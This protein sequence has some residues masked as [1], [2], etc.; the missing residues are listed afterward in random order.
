MDPLAN[1]M[2]T[3]VTFM[4][5]KVSK[6]DTHNYNQWKVDMEL[7]KSA[8]L[9][10][11]VH[12]ARPALPS[13]DWLKKEVLVLT[14]IRQHCT[15]DAGSLI[16]DLF[17]ANT[18]WDTLKASFEQDTDENENRLWGDFSIQM[19]DSEKMQ[20]YISRMKSMVSKLK[21]LEET[22]PDGR[23]VDRLVHGMATTRLCGD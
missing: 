13:E 9:W 21:D 1:D 4:L 18:A 2:L 3:M 20:E 19:K 16:S 22:V 5:S 23:I 10:S 6:L 17:T 14:D 7:S 8:I 12:D 11:I 15:S